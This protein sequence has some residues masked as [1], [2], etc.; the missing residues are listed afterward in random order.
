MEI[1]VKTGCL[2]SAPKDGVSPCGS[3]CY[4]MTA[5]KTAFEFIGKNITVQMIS[6]GTKAGP[7]VRV[8]FTTMLKTAIETN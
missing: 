2:S 8:M 3:D 5:A 6:A 4:C 7:G 1:A